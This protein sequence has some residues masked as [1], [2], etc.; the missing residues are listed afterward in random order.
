LTG[1]I[2]VLHHFGAHHEVKGSERQGFDLG[3][4]GGGLVEHQLRAALAGSV[5]TAGARVEA[6]DG[7]APVLQLCGESA[8]PAA[9]IQN[10]R[11]VRDLL[12]PL[13]Q[14]LQRFEQVDL[15]VGILS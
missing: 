6:Y 4:T 9:Q 14:S 13:Q 10:A 3:R 2:T 15:G 8:I 12:K 5:D 1:C 11:C 7:V